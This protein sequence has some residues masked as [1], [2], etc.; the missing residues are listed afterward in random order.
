MRVRLL[1]P[2]LFV[3]KLT[4]QHLPVSGTSTAF[5]GFLGLL[6]TAVWATQ[7]LY[8]CGSFF[9]GPLTVAAVSGLRSRFESLDLLANNLANSATSGYKSDS[10]FYGM[11]TSADGRDPITGDASFT[12]PVVERQWTDRG[13]QPRCT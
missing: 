6:Q 7:L 2:R 13:R 10:E 9:M 3:N 8:L 4:A 12:L 1:T 11:Y 5:Q